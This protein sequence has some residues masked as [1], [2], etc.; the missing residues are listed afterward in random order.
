MSCKSRG[1]MLVTLAINSNQQNENGF[2]ADNELQTEWDKFQSLYN[3]GKYDVSEN[4]LIDNIENQGEVNLENIYYDN[5]DETH[6][7][8]N[9]ET[10]NKEFQEEVKL[11][12][13]CVVNLDESH[14]PPHNETHE[15]DYN[16]C[17]D[18]DGDDITLEQEEGINQLDTIT[19]SEIKTKLEYITKS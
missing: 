17:S 12:N 1:K 13:N 6:N 2:G 8:A 7:T 11:V 9:N 15:P 14:S 18:C 5:L 16:P 19:E 4:I 3:E 10:Y